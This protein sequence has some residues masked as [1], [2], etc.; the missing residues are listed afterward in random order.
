MVV[1]LEKKSSEHPR[2]FQ[3][4]SAFA[5]THGPPESPPPPTAVQTRTF[6]CHLKS[7]IWLCL[8]ALNSCGKNPWH[9]YLPGDLDNHMSFRQWEL[10][11]KVGKELK[12]TALLIKPSLPGSG[13]LA[14]EK[15]SIL[16]GE[17]AGMCSTWHSS[18]LLWWLS[19][20]P[21]LGKICRCCYCSVAKSCPTLFNP[22]D[23]SM[24]GSSVF[25]YL[26]AFAQIQVHWVGDA[27]QPSQPLPSPSLFAF[28][29]FQHIRVFSYESV[30]HIRWSFSNSPSKEYS[31]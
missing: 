31:G 6:L 4:V 21:W 25:H 15:D 30:L 7:H 23:R 22:M 11:P 24:P 18:T 9:I 13:P 28:N 19:A 26:L 10:T 12:H 1:D 27:I 14:G 3:G 29:P 8:M 16:C 20:I 5:T 17:H 2:G